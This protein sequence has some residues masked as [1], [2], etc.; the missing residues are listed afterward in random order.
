MRV[1]PFNELLLQQNLPANG[2]KYVLV[3]GEGLPENYSSGPAWKPMPE[4]YEKFHAKLPEGKNVAMVI[5]IKHH[6]IKFI[7]V[8]NRRTTDSIYSYTTAVRHLQ[9]KFS[10]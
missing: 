7:D 2:E 5:K 3:S 4:D 8:V 10:N 1:I 6:K 9:D